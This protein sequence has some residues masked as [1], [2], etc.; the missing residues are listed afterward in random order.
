[1]L[2]VI[3]GPTYRC[4][5]FST[6]GVPQLD[7]ANCDGAG[8][9]WILMQAQV[10]QVTELFTANNEKRKFDPNLPTPNCHLNDQDHPGQD[11]DDTPPP[12]GKR[13]KI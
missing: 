7:L 3:I 6:T 8:G 13:I 12:Q 5:G 11:E 9:H 4:V 1:M 2:G 10:I